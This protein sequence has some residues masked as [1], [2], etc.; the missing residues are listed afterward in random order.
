MQQTLSNSPSIGHQRAATAWQRGNVAQWVTAFYAAR[1]V[2]NLRKGETIALARDIA[3]SVDT[4]E[5]LA[6]AALAYRFLFRHGA[7]DTVCRNKLR[8]ARRRLSYL[9]FVSAWRALRREVDPA[10][11][12][13]D[14]LTAAEEGSGVR[15]LD[16]ALSGRLGG[17]DGPKENVLGVGEYRLPTFD[18]TSDLFRQAIGT[19]HYRV[20]LVD[21]AAEQV[22]VRYG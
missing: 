1:V 20:V 12:L 8:W 21:A 5:R 10:D 3:R 16:A 13:A 19:G 7:A 11:V 6:M 14:I 22:I 9:H 4:V 17:G 2:G 15:V 18:P